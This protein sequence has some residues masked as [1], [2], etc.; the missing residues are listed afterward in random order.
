MRSRN[1]REEGAFESLDQIA[2]WVLR[3][4]TETGSQD[5]GNLCWAFATARMPSS[6]NIW[7]A[8]GKE[9]GLKMRSLKPQELSSTVWALATSLNYDP[10]VLEGTTETLQS[11]KIRDFKAQS[12]SSTA[13]ALAALAVNLMM[14]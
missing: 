7:E 9:A 5:L 14:M 12:L 3:H 8:L 1:L 13:W 10:A 2:G 11:L 4:V 6:A